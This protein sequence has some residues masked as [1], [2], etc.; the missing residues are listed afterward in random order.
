MDSTEFSQTKSS[1]LPRLKKELEDLENQDLR[2]IILTPDS[3]QKEKI[4]LEGDTLLNFTSNNYLGLA[5]DPALISA[6]VEATETYGTSVA[7]SRLLVGSTPLHDQLE[8]S[9]AALKKC[10]SALL[11]SAGY[12]ANIGVISALTSPGDI[13]FS[14]S[15]N[16][17]SIIDGTR[18]SRAETVV[19]RHLDLEHL[20]QLLSEAGPR[21]KFVVTETVFSMDG[22]LVDL[23]KLHAIVKK[24]G[25]VLIVDEAHATGVLGK[26]GGGAFD[27]FSIDPAETII[28]GTFSKALGSVGGFVAGPSTVIEYLKNRSRS[29]IFNTALP[30]SAVGAALVALEKVVAEPDRRSQ[31]VELSEYLRSGLVEAGFS[32]SNSQTQ[33]VPMIVG[34]A[35]QALSVEK[36]LRNAGILAKAIRPPT[37]PEGTSRIRFNLNAKFDKEDI[38][39]VLDAV[40]NWSFGTEYE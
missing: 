3:G 20:E 8:E 37:V 27:H 21:Q 22:D 32:V 14:D 7:A 1:L 34:E 24:H 39:K 23:P 5:T 18:L 28:I 40:K 11:Y 35:V 33:I 13:V 12:L 10:S 4:V 31:I 15:L 30:P 26:S 29:F 6:S 9:I 2:R 16:H 38:D 17:A 19:Y 36:H 25:A